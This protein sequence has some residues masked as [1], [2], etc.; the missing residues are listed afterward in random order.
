[1]QHGRFNVRTARCSQCLETAGSLDTVD[2][3]QLAMRLNKITGCTP[4]LAVRLGLN[5]W[6]SRL[7]LNLTFVTVRDQ[8]TQASKQVADNVQHLNPLN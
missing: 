1:M 2:N 3:K 8:G 4:Q 7:P 5:V 6:V